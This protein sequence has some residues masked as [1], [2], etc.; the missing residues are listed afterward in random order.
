[1]VGQTALDPFQVRIGP[2]D[3]VHRHDDRHFR[4]MGVIHRLDG[5][6]HD[7]VIR[8]HHQH[9]D[10][11]DLGAPCAHSRKGFV[12]GSIEEGHPP[13]LQPDVVGADMLGNAA[14]L[15]VGH[16]GAADGVEQ[17]RLAVVH[18]SHDGHHRGSQLQSFRGVHDLMLILQRRLDVEGHVLDLV[19]EFVCPPG[20]RCRSRAPG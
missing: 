16:M 5:L 17:R 12:S 8:G 9:H 14:S 18:V 1:M 20:S 3:L 15:R 7:A 10:V 11:R 2:V 13:A 6:R 4:G 19:I